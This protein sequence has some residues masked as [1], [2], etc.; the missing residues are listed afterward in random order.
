MG[1]KKEKEQTSLRTLRLVSGL[2]R[3]TNDGRV[4]VSFE[5]K[6]LRIAEITG[7]FKDKEVQVFKLDVN[8]IISMD[9]ITEENIVEK[10]KCVVGRGVAGAILFGPVGAII[11]TASGA[12]TEKVVDKKGDFVISYYG[13]EEDDIKTINFSFQ[14][15]PINNDAKYAFIEYYHKH[16]SGNFQSNENGDIIL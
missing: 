2:P 5:D 9:V 14:Y 10:Q 11:G 6:N 13:N 4:Y 3:K 7:V 15:D 12:Q 1:K 8:K 16:Y